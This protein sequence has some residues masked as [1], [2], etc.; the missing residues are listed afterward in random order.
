MPVCLCLYI[1]NTITFESLDVKI[2][3]RTFGIYPGDAG[4]VRI[5]HQVKV[6]V[7]GAKMFHDFYSRNAK[8]RSTKT[9]VL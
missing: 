2:H 8:L 1:C 4:Q 9:L 5:N 7:T 6:K 3:F